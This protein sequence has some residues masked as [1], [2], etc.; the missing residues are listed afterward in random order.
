MSAASRRRVAAAL[1]WAPLGLLGLAFVIWPGLDLALSA[2]VHDP[3]RAPAFLAADHL[4]VRASYVAVP[5]LGRG[6]LLAAAAVTLWPRERV[7]RWRRRAA[8]LL[9]VALLGNGAAVTWLLKDHGGRPRPLAVHAFGGDQP[10]V[11]ALRPG[12]PC[13]HNCSFVSGHAAAGYTLMAVGLLSAPATRR[14]WAAVGLAAG[15]AIGAGRVLQ[16]GHFASDVVFAAIV[17]GA[18]C[19]LLRAAWLRARLRRRR[20]LASLARRRAR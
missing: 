7:G 16:G 18:V 19:A 15:T 8:L 9:G 2:A 5:W 20:R 10:F 17:I 6:V 1:R 12:G 14:R 3:G 11:A 4:L 13:G